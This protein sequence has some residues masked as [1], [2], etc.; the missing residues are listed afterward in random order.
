MVS[1][2]A[3]VRGRFFLNKNHVTRTAL[4]KT[5]MVKWTKMKMQME[6]DGFAALGTVVIQFLSSV[7]KNLLW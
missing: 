2:G 7:L 6:M 4:T 1:V 5:V 3:F